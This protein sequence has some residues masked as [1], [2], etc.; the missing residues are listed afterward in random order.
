MSSGDARPPATGQ[1]DNNEDR[2]FSLL[3]R[4]LQ[5]MEEDYRRTVEATIPSAEGGQQHSASNGHANGQA[6][7]E[8]EDE[9]D[10]AVPDGYAALG[11]D[12]DDEDDE[13]EE[14][15]ESRINLD[16]VAPQEAE[17]GKQTQEDPTLSSDEV[18]QIRN[19]MSSLDLPA[20]EWAKN[21]D[22]DTLMQQVGAVMA[23]HTAAKGA[24]VKDQ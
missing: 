12:D 6:E 2:I 21:L 20:P 1:G 18:N 22:N 8:E 11:G 5:A 19:A 24:P 7:S 9:D 10:A 15:Q 14:T 4:R 23:K 16:S 13:D 3:E 17:L